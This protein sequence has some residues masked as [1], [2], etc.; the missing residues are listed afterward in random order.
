VHVTLAFG[1]MAPHMTRISRKKG[2]IPIYF[3]SGFFN[4]IIVFFCYFNLILMG[5]FPLL[6]DLQPDLRPYF[7][8]KLGYD[9]QTEII[10]KPGMF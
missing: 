9:P 7:G 3:P 5:F 4:Y 8:R 1:H 10:Y 2:N 6:E